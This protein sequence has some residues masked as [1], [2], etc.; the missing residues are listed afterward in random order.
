MLTNLEFAMHRRFAST[1]PTRSA[2]EESITHFEAALARDPTF[3]PAYVGL[4][5]AYGKLATTLV[6][7]FPSSE[8]S[9]KAMAAV[10]RALRQDPK[11]PEAHAAM[12]A[13][14]RDQWRWQEGEDGFRRALVLDPNSADIHLRMAFALLTV[15]SQS[16]EAIRLAW[17]AR[18]LDPLSPG[19]AARLGWNLYLARRYDEAI[20]ECRKALQLHGGDLLAPLFFMGLALAQTAEFDEAIDVLE[21]AGAIS[22]QPPGILGSLAYTYGR[23]GRRPEALRMLDRLT[24]QRETAYVPPAAFV[25]AYVGLGEHDRAFT[26]LERAYEDHST[27]MILLRVSPELDPLRDDPRFADLLR[28]VGLAP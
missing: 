1:G 22:K 24:R 11:L 23:A 7:A 18:V 16:E 17:R 10:E 27:L 14:R 3:A 13:I 26:W 25:L 6:G 28:R 12:A 5:R 9:P 15:R 21:R 19:T 4:A 8:I 2:V 20:Q